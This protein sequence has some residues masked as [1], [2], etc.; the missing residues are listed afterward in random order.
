MIDLVLKGIFKVGDD[1]EFITD[2]TWL[3]SYFTEKYKHSIK[4]L[5]ESNFLPV[6]IKFLK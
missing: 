5:I 3:L 4:K 2:A 1:S 6:I